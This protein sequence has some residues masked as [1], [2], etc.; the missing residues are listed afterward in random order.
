MQAIIFL[1][2]AKVWLYFDLA[3]IIMTICIIIAVSCM[4]KLLIAIH[5]V[6]YDWLKMVLRGGF[7][8]KCLFENHEFADYFIGE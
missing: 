6:Q 1:R 5:V 8:E 4:F 3:K 7:L 2:R